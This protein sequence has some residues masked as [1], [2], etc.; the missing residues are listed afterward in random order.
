MKQYAGSEQNIQ[1]D[2]A[3]YLEY[4]GYYTLRINSGKVKSSWDYKGKAGMKKYESWIQLAPKG[5]PD[6]LV[7]SPQ[8]IASFIEFKK[9]NKERTPEQIRMATIIESKNIKVY[10]IKSLADLTPI[11]G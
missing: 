1:N 7:I 2:C 5:T 9:P 11:Y 8:G 4:R 3:Q 6:M 10:V